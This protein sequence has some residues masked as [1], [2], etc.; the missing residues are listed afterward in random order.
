MYLL[1]GNEVIKKTA[2]VLKPYIIGNLFKKLTRFQI[3][4]DATI[5]IL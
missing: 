5:F 4:K 2:Q 3:L 1:I